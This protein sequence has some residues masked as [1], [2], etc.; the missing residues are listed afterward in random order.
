[1]GFKRGYVLSWHEILSADFRLN[2]PAFDQLC[3][4]FIRTPVSLITP[5]RL[6]FHSNACESD[7]TLPLELLLVRRTTQEQ[8]CYY[9]CIFCLSPYSAIKQV[10]A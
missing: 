9:F 8:P 3:S 1:M 10:S 7:N 6:S 5:F 2:F 4:S